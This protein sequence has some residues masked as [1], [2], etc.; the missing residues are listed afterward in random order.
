MYIRQ[1]S[2]VTRTC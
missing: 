1:R 2:S